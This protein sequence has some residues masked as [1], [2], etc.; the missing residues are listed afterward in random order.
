[1]TIKQRALDIKNFFG[2]PP[3][4]ENAMKKIESKKED[5]LK[6]NVMNKVA[7]V[8]NNVPKLKPNKKKMDKFIKM[9]K[10]LNE[11]RLEYYDK[12]KNEV[13]EGTYKKLVEEMKNLENKSKKTEEEW[14]NL[15]LMQFYLILNEYIGRAIEFRKLRLRK[16]EGGNY[17]QGNT[18]YI[19]EYKKGAYQ[20]SD[21]GYD[22]LKEGLIKVKIPSEVMKS[23]NALRRLREGSMFVFGNGQTEMS[24]SAFS[25]YQ[26]RVLGHSTNE[27]RKMLIQQR[28]GVTSQVWQ[29]IEG[30][31]RKANHTMTTQRGHYV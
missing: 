30:A 3:S 4:F 22:K 9:Q 21:G 15:L 28:E 11:K 19:N 20:K 13:P 14:Q 17:I 29:K 23:V 16:N 18:L 8:L 27:L 12:K 25:K 10:D 7:S 31:A 1:M 6:S 5:H 26:K 2:D 24:Q